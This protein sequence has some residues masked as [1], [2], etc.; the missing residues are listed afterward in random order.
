MPRPARITTDELLDA[1]AGLT[2]ERGPAGLSVSNVARRLGVPSGS[3]YHRFA[4]RDEMTAAMWLRSIERFQEGWL[5]AV[6]D[7]H[8]VEAVR[9]AAQHVLAWCREH[10]TDAQIALLYRSRDLVDGDWPPGYRERNERQRIAVE[11]GMGAL[12]GR[13]EGSAEEVRRRLRFATVAVPLGAVRPSLVAGQPPPS[14]IDQL[15]DEAVRAV[16]APLTPKEAT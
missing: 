13:F 6:D 12:A 15:V 14:Y 7:P 4:S 9:G 1:A 10:P 8:P 11:V 2:L 16:L 3:M 5:A